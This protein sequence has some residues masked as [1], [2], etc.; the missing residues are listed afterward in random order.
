[1]NSFRGSEYALPLLY[2]VVAP[3]LLFVV[4]LTIVTSRITRVIFG[5]DPAAALREQHPAS[6]TIVT[7]TGSCTIGLLLI[8][9]LLP[10]AL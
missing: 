5:F 10:R 7:L 4:A 3:L 8:A 1:M 9:L 6:W 2:V